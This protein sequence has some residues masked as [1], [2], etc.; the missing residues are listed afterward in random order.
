MKPIKCVVVGDDYVGKTSLLITYNTKSFPHD[1]IPTTYDNL[2]NNSPFNFNFYDTTNDHPQLNQFIYE[3]SD[4]FIICFSLVS[5]KSME[6]VS[7]FFGQAIQKVC[8]HSLKILVG[9]KRD[10]R[11]EFDDNKEKFIS[12]GMSP[13]LKEKGEE[14]KKKIGAKFYIE[15]SSLKQINVNEIF[16]YENV[17]D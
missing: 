8:P 16:D 12:R 7:T 11:D 17:I 4:V 2:S 15:C 1:F 5:P 13:I 3:N 10:L 9:T 6:N 14:L